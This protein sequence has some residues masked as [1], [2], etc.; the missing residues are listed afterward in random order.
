M[1]RSLIVLSRERLS[2]PTGEALQ[3][4]G[5]AKANYLTTHSKLHPPLLP[6]KNPSKRL[7]VLITEVP[8]ACTYTPSPP[9]TDRAN[10]SAQRV[11]GDSADNWEFLGVSRDVAGDLS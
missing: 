3:A 6:S 4:H 11:P 7:A 10:P 5:E 1:T 8:I 2:T 9:K